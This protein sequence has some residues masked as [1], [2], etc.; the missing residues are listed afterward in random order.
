MAQIHITLRSLALAVAQCS[1]LLL[2]AQ[3]PLQPQWI[4]TWPYG[5][6]QASLYS[7]VPPWKDNH[8]VVDPVTGLLH[9]TVS[10]EDMLYS[11]RFE[12]LHT[13]A[14][15]G[16]D[17][18]GPEPIVLGPEP[19][20]LLYNHAYNGSSV[21]DLVIHDGEVFAGLSY[22]VSGPTYE[23]WANQCQGGAMNMD[24]W[25]VS[26]NNN[27]DWA[28]AVPCP[29]TDG[30]IVL[31]SVPGSPFI[32]AHDRAG[33]VQWRVEIPSPT[34]DLV[35]QDGIAY[36]LTSTTVQRIDLASATLLTEVPLTTWESKIAVRNGALYTARY[37][38]DG[39]ILRKRAMDGTLFWEHDLE[40]GSGAELTGMVVDAADGLW[41]TVSR[42]DWDVENMVGGYLLGVDANGSALQ[43][44]TYGDALHSLATDGS[45]L[46]MT[47]WSDNT[48]TETFLIGVDIAMITGLEDGSNPVRST[49]VWPIPANT[50]LTVE[51]PDG[52]WQLELLDA[53][54]RVVGHWSVSASNKQHSVDVSAVSNGRYVLIAR[55]AK[56]LHSSAVIIAR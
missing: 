25:R 47:G 27:F 16:M 51:L 3:S 19:T 9:V 48:G 44:R 36:A 18:T 11:P 12:L 34:T 38:G 10:D 42:I 17:L 24:R 13:F 35:I 32:V 26:N 29:A 31:F 52:T 40:V 15:D 43:T 39:Y 54:G 8:V 14:S 22:F 46:Y 4:H 56:G 28:G 21:P 20:P 45:M 2:L 5:N 23:H 37:A 30:N 41:A 49:R 55:G 53:V 1:S 33:W 6:D 50:L 7:L